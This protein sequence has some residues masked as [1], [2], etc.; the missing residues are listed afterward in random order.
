MPM[1]RTTIELNIAKKGFVPELAHS[2]E[3]PPQKL[4]QMM[5]RDVTK[6]QPTTA[7]SSPKLALPKP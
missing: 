3:T 2:S 5:F 4:A 7:A 6:T 1:Q